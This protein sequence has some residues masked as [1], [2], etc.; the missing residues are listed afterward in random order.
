MA[1]PSLSAPA[2][3]RGV[4][5][6]MA[7]LVVQAMGHSFVL[8]VLP[9]LGRQMG[10]ADVRIGLI[11][12]LSALVLSL[13]APLWGMIGDTWGRRRVI[14]IALA[15][16]AAFPALL[17]LLLYGR[18]SLGVSATATFAMLL[19]LR[20]VLAALGG[21]LMPA[22]QAYLADVT[23]REGRARGMG[24]MGAA[25]G[26]GGL[27]GAG[28]AFALGGRGWMPA[29]GLL[30]GVAA[31][32]VILVWR[33][34]SEPPRAVLPQTSGAVRLRPLAPFLGITISGLAVY[35]LIGQVT[36]LRLQ[37][38]FGLSL[39][40]SI[41]TA[42]GLMMLTMLAMITAQGLIVP[43]LAR[44]PGTLLRVGSVVALLAGLLALAAPQVA[45]LGVA[46]AGLGAG[47]GLT[48]PGNL[49][50]LSLR[51]GPGVQAR[52]AGI[53][54]LAQGAGL[55]LGPLLGAG[56]HQISPVAPY[57]AATGF[58]LGVGVLAWG[59][60]RGGCSPDALARS[61]ADRPQG[62]AAHTEAL[63]SKETAS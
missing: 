62:R 54:A 11:L 52:V 21:G 36:V 14:L 22:A 4:T 44:T 2:L 7:G 50:A 53:N 30:S 49:T 46:M 38:G 37:D 12:S 19:A 56:L 16:A 51:G 10:I 26:L 42:G 29:L 55:A 8:I 6:L 23:S 28:L 39:E 13:S 47:L 59:A 61:P 5:L 15:A 45:V 33:G 24:G 35:S 34:L 17:A 63:P 48:L 20:L 3:R 58:L 18:L 27:A 41:G 43:R 25:F 57:G 1:F 9:A 40:A 60:T 31:L 32:V